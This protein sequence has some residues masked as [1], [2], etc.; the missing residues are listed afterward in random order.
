MH[1]AVSDHDDVQP[2]VGCVCVNTVRCAIHSRSSLSGHKPTPLISVTSNA[3]P[4]LAST[5]PFIV[6]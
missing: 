1:I 2:V 4:G 6:I 3:K 5:W